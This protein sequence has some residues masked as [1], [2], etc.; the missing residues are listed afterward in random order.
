MANYSGRPA[1]EARIRASR[2]AFDA[3]PL[4]IKAAVWDAMQPWCALHISD[5]LR[6]LGV[7][8]TIAMIAEADADICAQR[9]PWMSDKQLRVGMRRED[10]PKSPHQ[11]ADATQLRSHAHLYAGR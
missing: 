6:R 3:L 7:R 4:P 2:E 9:R 5:H 1:G 8:A 10:M 11:A